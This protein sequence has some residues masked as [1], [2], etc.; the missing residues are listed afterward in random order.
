MLKFL[1]KDPKKKLEKQYAA[2]VKEAREA[3]RA[4]KIPLFATLT[5]EAEELERRLEELEDSP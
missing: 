5:A 1:Q 4:G 3:Q 2:K